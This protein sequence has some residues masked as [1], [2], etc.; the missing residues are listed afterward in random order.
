MAGTSET[1]KV[2][3]KE[4]IP[5]AQDVIDGAAQAKTAE[6]SAKVRTGIN[7]K[8]EAKDLARIAGSPRLLYITFCLSVAAIIGVFLPQLERVIYPDTAQ[9][10]WQAA[11]NADK[12]E[13]QI[14]LRE[15][16]TKLSEIEAQFSEFGAEIRQ[17][18][19]DRDKNQDADL[20]VVAKDLQILAAEIATITAEIDKK[21]SEQATKQPPAPQASAIWF[22]GLA[23]AS[24]L[25]QDL[26]YWKS[27]LP[28]ITPPAGGWGPVQSDIIQALSTSET[29]SHQRLI[30]DAYALVEAAHLAPPSTDR[31]RSYATD[32]ESGWLS[33]V[34]N[35]L[36]FEKI[37]SH[38]QDEIDPNVIEFNRLVS[39]GA[40]A[41]IAK[42]LVAMENLALSDVQHWHAKFESRT[43]LDALIASAFDSSGS[44]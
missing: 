31:Q 26:G 6:K 7:D 16:E 14:A 3:H 43:S 41:P 23:T 28:Q 21:F 24:Q 18:Q 39:N 10:A 19:I 30:S 33:W 35:V 38:P 2:P 42:A 20:A 8:N 36:R 40:L 11:R 9:P 1:E 44:L 4:D 37:E 34:H 29:A 32:S 27:R 22:E 13:L 15:I 5:A 12:A 25:G 17:N